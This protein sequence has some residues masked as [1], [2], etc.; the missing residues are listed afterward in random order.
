MNSGNVLFGVLA[1]IAFGAV[2]GVLV[3][4]EKGST[5]RKQLSDFRDGMEETLQSK[6]D[7][8]VESMRA[9]MESDVKSVEKITSKVRSIADNAKKEVLNGNA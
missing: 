2:L 5:T 4:P 8:L 9:R 1:G 6:L 7:K 3:A